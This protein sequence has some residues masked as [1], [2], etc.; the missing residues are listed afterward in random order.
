MAD[1][2]LPLHLKSDG[3][4]AVA[5]KTRQNYV[6]D[7]FESRPSMQFL[8]QTSLSLD[9]KLYDEATNQWG[10]EKW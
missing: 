1:Q 5:Y 3:V 6:S 2:N 10:K 7:T 8:Q 4:F 9:T